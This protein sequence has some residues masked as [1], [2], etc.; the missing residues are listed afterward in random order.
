MATKKAT[1]GRPVII[2]TEARG[3]FFGY[4]TKTAGDIVQLKRARNCI[5]WARS[6]GGVLG[7]AATGPDANCRIGARADIE[8]RK[9]TA[10]LEVTKAAEAAW[11]SSPSVS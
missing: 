11:E 6:V 1:K 10:V 3:V 8:L 5:Y 9:V 4:A 2:C 7:L